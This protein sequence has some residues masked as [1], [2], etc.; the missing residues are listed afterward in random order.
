MIATD[1]TNIKTILLSLSI[2][3]AGIVLKNGLIIKINKKDFIT[4]KNMVLISFTLLY[5]I[6]S[7]LSD[8]HKMNWHQLVP[9][10]KHCYLFVCVY[11]AVLVFLDQISACCCMIY[12]QPWWDVSHTWFSSK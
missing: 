6:K 10:L 1:K 3:A 12:T 8:G 7:D 4:L 11:H 5:H 9:S 2:N